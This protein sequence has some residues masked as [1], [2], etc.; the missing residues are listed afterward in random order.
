MTFR[1][2]SGGSRTGLKSAEL[3]DVAGQQCII[4]ILKDIT[5]QRL[6]E[7]KL[8]QAQKMEAI[9]QLS[10]G[11]AHDFNNLLSVIIGYSEVL[12]K[13]LP[14]GQELQK[15]LEQIKKAG[16]KA[17]LLTRQLLAFSRQQVLQAR[18]IDLNAAVLEVEKMLR[19]LISE[20]IEV[21]SK[22]DASLGSIHA[23]PGQMSQIIINLAVNARD[24]MP[25]G[26][27]LTIETANMEIDD[28]Y[29]RLHASPHPGPYVMLTVSDTGTGID[30]ATQAR[31]FDPFFTTKEVGKGTG[32]GLSTVY[33]VVKQSGGF[34][35]VYS[36]VGHGT[37]FK[38]YFPRVGPA[39]Q[40][41]S[42]ALKTVEDL[43]GTETILLV[44]D[45]EALRDLARHV[46]SSHG[47]KV[48]SADSAL[49]ALQ[50][51]RSSGHIDLLLTD[52]VMPGMDGPELAK[53][54]ALQQPGLKI[55]YMSGYTG[56]SH[57]GLLDPAAVLLAKPLRQDELLRII[58]NVL[59]SPVPAQGL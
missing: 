17:A 3:I 21:C 47:Y 51:V 29:A 35:S 48:I 27:R 25:N 18:V 52:V 10:G 28:D 41:E 22:L 42:P 53:R 36:E 59:K 14:P 19:R 58:R 24:A 49:H 20:N 11:I 8:L 43:R 38:I 9:G 33:G 50:I 5:E 46:L 12:E 4:A 6:L 32:L 45:A 40:L 55:V 37:T 26:G 56:F 54:L 23:D 16:E 39:Q 7:K 34:I 2:K 30:A 44:E 31:I 13:E 15:H 1:T 57:I